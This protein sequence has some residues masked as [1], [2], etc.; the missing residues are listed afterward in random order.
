MGLRFLRLSASNSPISSEEG[1]A[2]PQSWKGSTDRG[3]TK[4]HRAN[5][6]ISLDEPSLS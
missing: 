3:G 4:L 6:L 1:P 2:I 5:R